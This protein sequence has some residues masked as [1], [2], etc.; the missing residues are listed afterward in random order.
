M[1]HATIRTAIHE[2]DRQLRRTATRFGEESR[3]IRLRTG[4]SQAAVARA[5]GV[6]R[7][8]ICRMEAGDPT[9]ADRIRARAA[10]VLG[11]DFRLGLYPDAAPLIHDAAHARLVEALLR[12]RHPSWR[13]KVEAPV[14]G[15]GRRSTDLRLDRGDATILFEVET[16]V[17]AL[18][19]IIREGEDKRSAVAAAVAADVVGRRRRRAARARDPRLAT[20]PTPS[21][22]G[23]G[24]SRD[25]QV[26]VPRVDRRYPARADL[27]RYALARR[28]APLAR[29]RHPA[30]RAV[31][32]R[33]G[34]ATMTS[35]RCSLRPLPVTY[36]ADLRPMSRRVHIWPDG[37]VDGWAG[38][39]SGPGRRSSTSR[40]TPCRTRVSPRRT[41]RR[42]GC[43]STRTRGTDRS[44][45]RP[46]SP[47]SR[48]SRCAGH[49]S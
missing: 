27:G 9:V 12:L 14:P 36:A 5:I 25:D 10:A 13:A 1:P 19:A 41:G 49:P 39:V 40:T 29:C 37:A 47:R 23:G 33:H 24:S 26:S 21:N 30:C 4:V 15:T 42:T 28:R 44:V 22:P 38:T 18:E 48:S 2:G 17:H 3:L 11:A 34:R 7:A 46:G 35:R 43:R 16:H 31:A 20:N 6:D 8:T 45:S 32:S